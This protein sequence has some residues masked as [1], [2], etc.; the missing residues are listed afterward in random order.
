MAIVESCKAWLAGLPPG[1]LL[2]QVKPAV[3]DG[4][5]LSAVRARIKK[6]QKWSACQCRALVASLPVKP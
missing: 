4:L 2:E 6:L 5:S 3:E 1:T